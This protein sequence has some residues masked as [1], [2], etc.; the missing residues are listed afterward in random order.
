MAAPAYTVILTYKDSTERTSSVKFHVESDASVD[1]LRASVYAMAKAIDPLTD[2]VLVDA[3][4]ILPVEPGWWQ[5][6]LG[7][8]LKSVV[9]AECDI[10]NKGFFQFRSDTGF[11][12]SLTIP[13]INNAV[14]DDTTNLIDTALSDVADFVDAM[15][16]S[17]WQEE[18]A[19][20]LY[21][22]VPTDNRGAQ[23][24]ELT[25]AYQQYR[26]SGKTRS[27]LKKL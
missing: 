15:T 21:T 26:A 3:N 8:G 4:I 13:G 11:Y 16:T 10:E 2:C 9:A 6:L 27:A 12:S 19:T 14:V 20:V 23:L 22:T 17:G 5:T 18:I 1:Q 7:S 25:A 24:A